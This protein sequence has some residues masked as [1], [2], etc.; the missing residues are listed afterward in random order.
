MSDLQFSLIV[1]GVTIIGGVCLYNWVQE[2]NYRKRLDQAF[3]TAPEDVLLP[4]G[5]DVSE[6]KIEP[7]LQP[8][9]A[10]P[11]AIR[12]EGSG[13]PAPARQ[14]SGSARMDPDADLDCVAEIET[15]TVVAEGPLDELLTR[16]AGCGRP[17]RVLGLNADTAAWEE[18]TRGR[19]ARYRGL[20]LAL[21]LVNRS[22]TAN[23]AQLAMF[24]DAARSCAEKIA[25]RAILPDA[26]AALKA[27][28]D[29]DAFCSEVDVAIGVNVVAEEGVT[30][31][32]ARIRELAEAAGF[33]LEPDGVFH[34]RAGQRRTLFTLDN[35]QPAPFLP[36]RLKSLATPGVTL[37]LDVPRVAD[38]A[39]VLDRML[40]IGRELA[41]ALGGKLV[42]D[43]RA[44]LSEAGVARIREQL[45]SINAALA[46]RGITAGGERALRLFS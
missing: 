11:R 5:R 16:M 27:A 42:D 33:T 25:G 35:H 21:Q 10:A 32:G 26:H 37:M 44:T 17:T 3:G 8:V 20:K 23:A 46:A 36:E 1:I 28:Q 9:P 38:G 14:V 29:L 41:A 7:Q 45:Q 15:G 19:S 31:S 24:C 22:G 12:T 39:A 30:F 6:G 13:A 18:V 40:D 2:R 34:Y 4:R 43:N